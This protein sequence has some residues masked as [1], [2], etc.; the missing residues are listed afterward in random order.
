MAA[1]IKDGAAS[2]TVSFRFSN[3]FHYKSLAFSWSYLLNLYTWSCSFHPSS[4]HVGM[5]TR[6]IC[7]TGL[8]KKR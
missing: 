5:I 7:H 8:Q 3:A 6:G 2:N 4:Q 1:P